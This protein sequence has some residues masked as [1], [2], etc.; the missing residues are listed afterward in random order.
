MPAAQHQVGVGI[1]GGFHQR[2][3][4]QLVDAEMTVRMGRRAHGIAGDA[5]AAVGAVLE[6]HRQVEAAD[7]FA[8]NLRLAG[9]RTDGRPGQQ[10]IEVARH[11]R[12]Q[13]FGGERQAQR[14]HVQHQAT[15]QLQ[16]IAH[17]V[18]AIQ[19][20]IVG[21]TLP[22][23]RGA[24]LF[25]V[26]AHHQQQLVAHF[27]R[28]IGQAPGVIQ[29]RG[30]IVDGTG[31][32]HHQQA[33]IAAIEDRANGLA[34]IVHTGGQGGFQRQALAQ[35][36]G[37]RQGLGDASRGDGRLECG[38]LGGSVHLANSLCVPA[39]EPPGTSESIVRVV[40]ARRR[41]G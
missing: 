36:G 5:Q 1:A 6:T 3:V 39:A 30:G 24:R 7:Q 17:G 28:Q 12:L 8:V 16:P 20:R 27:G 23:D 14:Q 25:H 13:Q 26:G 18:T 21:Q 2:R 38:E 35:Q 31:A 15:R 19:M 4:P 32:D 11:Q 29:G 9:A 10:V 40:S 37:R 41:H 22:A 34:L 33:R